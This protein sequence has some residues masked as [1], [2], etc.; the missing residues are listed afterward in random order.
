MNLSDG[1]NNLKV[2]GVNDPYLYV[3]SYKSMFGWHIEDL[4]LCSINFLH[5]GKPKLNNLLHIDSGTLCHNMRVVEWSNLL[6]HYLWMVLA[7][8]INF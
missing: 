4:D 2:S 6:R 7:N 5:E 3:G 8:A 1:L